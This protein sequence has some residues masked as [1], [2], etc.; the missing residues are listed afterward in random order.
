MLTRAF[1]GDALEKFLNG[2]LTSGF[3]KK[4][5][6]CSFLKNKQW[7][8]ILG[9]AR[10]L[11]AHFAKLVC[12]GSTGSHRMH[13]SSVRPLATSVGTVRLPHLVQWLT[14]CIGISRQSDRSL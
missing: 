9:M 4:P 10:G 6:P 5:A 7:F 3:G 1:N 14:S 13:F 8:Q 12:I 2:F 11:S